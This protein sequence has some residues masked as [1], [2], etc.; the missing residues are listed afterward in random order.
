MTDLYWLEVGLQNSREFS[1]VETF[2][3]YS[4]EFIRPAAVFTKI[5]STKIDLKS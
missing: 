3:E 1:N 4:R 5:L 2:Q